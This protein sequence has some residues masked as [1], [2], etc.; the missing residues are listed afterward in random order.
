LRPNRSDGKKKG[1][2][3]GKAIKRKFWGTEITENKRRS[4]LVTNKMM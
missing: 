4:Y 1:K 3:G 2:I